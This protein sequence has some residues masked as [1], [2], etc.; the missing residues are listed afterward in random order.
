MRNWRA[1]K[2]LGNEPV[3]FSSQVERATGTLVLGGRYSDSNWINSFELNTNEWNPDRPATEGLPSH[4][5][6]SIPDRRFINLSS[7]PE[8]DPKR[9]ESLSYLSSGPSTSSWCG[10]IASI[11]RSKGNIRESDQVQNHPPRR[12]ALMRRRR[13]YWIRLQPYL[14]R[15]APFTRHY[16]PSFYLGYC[17][18]CP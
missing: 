14:V 9:K 16:K 17:L 8:R 10:Y 12:Y 11:F 15:L 2:T 13:R 6:A 3:P 5:R 7:L 4:Q 1:S 18:G